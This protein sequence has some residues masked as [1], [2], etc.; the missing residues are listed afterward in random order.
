VVR[1]TGGQI[2][3][4]IV[5]DFPTVYKDRFGHKVKVGF[6]MLEVRRD[7]ATVDPAFC[8][9]LVGKLCSFASEGLTPLAS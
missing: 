9:S 5:R 7:G 1:A 6:R 4:G 2:K 8:F 3:V